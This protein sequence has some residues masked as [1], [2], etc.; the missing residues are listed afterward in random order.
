MMKVWMVFVRFEV[1]GRFL[2][3][4]WAVESHAVKRLDELTEC[5]R[6][7]GCSGNSSRSGFYAYIGTGEVVDVAL[8]GEAKP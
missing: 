1:N 2:D 8:P 7:F 4:Q 6:A 3:S 5:F